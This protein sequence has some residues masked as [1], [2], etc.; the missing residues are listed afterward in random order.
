MV[1]NWLISPRGRKA[2]N[3]VISKNNYGR[4]KGIAPVH[5]YYTSDSVEKFESLIILNKNTFWL[6]L[7]LKIL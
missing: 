1:L 2:V 7:I 6:K 3:E 5:R 4:D